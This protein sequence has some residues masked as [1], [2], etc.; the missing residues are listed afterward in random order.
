MEDCH[1]PVAFV[2]AIL[3]KFLGFYRIIVPHLNIGLCWKLTKPSI[4]RKAQSEVKRPLFGNRMVTEFSK[5]YLPMGKNP[6]FK[7]FLRMTN[8]YPH[9][10]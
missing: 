2:G 1:I 7:I 5:E 10:H 9:M 4:T 6:P 3:Q 8:K